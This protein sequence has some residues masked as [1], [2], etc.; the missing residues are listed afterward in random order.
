M[1]GVYL[2]P[3]RLLPVDRERSRRAADVLA[4]ALVALLPWSTSAFSVVL[5][6][7]IVAVVATLTRRDVADELRAPRTF[8]PVALATLVVVALAWGTG[9]FHERFGAATALFKLLALPLLFIQFRRG[10]LGRAAA[11]TFVLSNVP[12]LLYSFLSRAI[13]VVGGEQTFRTMP[14]I[15]MH[16]VP[17]VPFTDYILQAGFFLFAVFCLAHLAVDA[18]KEGRRGRAL[19]TLALAALF[20]LNVLFVHAGRTNLLMLPLYGV[21]FGLQRGGAKLALG[22]VF[23]VAA[24]AVAAWSV[25]PQLQARVTQMAAEIAAYRA[26]D[27]NTSGGQ[28]LEWARHSIRF[29][30]E[31]PILG[32]GTGSI[33]TLMRAAV[34]ASG[35]PAD[36]ITA[37]PHNQYFWVGVQTGLAGVA[38]MLAMWGAHLA[39]FRGASLAAFLGTAAV[40]Q[41]VVSGALNSHLSDFVPGWFY[42][43]A[44]GVLG[45]LALAARERAVKAPPR[46]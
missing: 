16:T 30:G 26:G 36:Q 21:L 13:F 31:K 10:D 22:L 24:L 14:I 29:I 34:T 37:N 32:H 44:V 8:L 18:W 27:V 9:T 38:L 28:R 20:L 2:V 6:I 40:L 15:G 46:A 7:W 25:S 11:A 23:G 19:A 3:D 43:L 4:L 35:A 42:V 5:P 1:S 33:V 41:N 12:I 45:G 39:L 17:G